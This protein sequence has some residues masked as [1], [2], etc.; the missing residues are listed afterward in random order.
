MDKE[1]L[2]KNRFWIV[3]GVAVVL[4]L[5]D[6]MLVLFVVPGKADKQQ[7]DIEAKWKADKGYSNFKHFSWVEAAK[8]EA[9]ALEKDSANV[10]KTLYDIQAKDALLGTWPKSMI[11]QFDF[12]GGKYAV[13]VAVKPAATALAS[14]P[15]DD[16]SHYSGILTATE[17]D[18]FDVQGK[19]KK[20]VTF[21]RAKDI[22][23]SDED[24]KG[25]SLEFGELA[26]FVGK[27]SKVVVTFVTGKF[28]GDELTPNE[29]AA[30]IKYYKE[31]LPEVLDEIG[32]VNKLGQPE[33]LLRYSGAGGF[34][35]G[36]GAGGFGAGRKGPGAGGGKG[37]GPQPPGVDIG[38]EEPEIAND[39]WIYR[40]NKIPPADNRFLGY[41]PDW[42]ENT[43]ARD[44]SDEIWAAQENLWLTREMYRRIKA[45]NDALAHFEYVSTDA[46]KWAKFR[47]F[48]WEIELKPSGTGVQAKLKNLRP[49]RQNIDNLHLL[50]R[51]KDKDSPPVLFPPS[52]KSFQGEALA[53]G[54]TFASEA[55][56]VAGTPLNGVFSVEQVLTV[57]TAAV[58]RLDMLLIGAG[59]QGDMAL[60]HRQAYLPLVSYNPK[61]VAKEEPSSGGKGP[62]GPP[63]GAKGFQGAAATASNLSKHGLVL[64][65]YIE[66]SAQSRKVPVMLT[67]VVDPEQLALVEAALDGSALRF[68]TTQV[69]WT[70]C[71]LTLGEAEPAVSAPPTFGGNP[72]GGKFGGP[73][74]FGKGGAGPGRAG[75]GMPEAPAGGGV[76]SQENL[77]LTVYGVLTIYE[78]PGRPAPGAPA[79]PATP[80]DPKD[81]K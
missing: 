68:L 6:W 30:Y 23:V 15:A 19:D 45:A 81:P 8:N 31:Q 80:A 71:Q 77:E 75:P 78:R 67:V 65:R 62:G 2:I 13:D 3:L 61:P 12:N 25:A 38:A 49:K 5:V 57:E 51:L 35:G 64:E 17:E 48:Y 74:G 16:E 36:M 73:G 76:E 22:K 37:F 59:A 29:I 40:P 43:N 14:L 28:F 20:T 10:H 24:S 58:K 4:A 21:H 32:A 63:P 52:D 72:K 1:A 54:G 56:E 66:K 44:I 53:P 7:K 46:L 27:N 34:T 50:V 18:Y 60:S 39:A 26:K 42:N 79:L 11:K 55:I 47:N 9:A 41:V 70:R 33:V 69:L